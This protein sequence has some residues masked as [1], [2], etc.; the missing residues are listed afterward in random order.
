V[1]RLRV[2]LARRTSGGL[3]ANPQDERAPTV[4]D[5][6]ETQLAQ[7]VGKYRGVIG[8]CYLVLGR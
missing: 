8:F 4:R 5:E 1:G 3:L 2:N 7:Y 6:L